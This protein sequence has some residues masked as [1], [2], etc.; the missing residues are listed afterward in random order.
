MRILDVFDLSKQ[1]GDS[2]ALEEISF[3]LESGD[4]LFVGGQNG[5]GK[6]TLL[7]IISGLRKPTTGSCKLT[8]TS[9]FISGV[10]DDSFLYADLTVE[11]N[12][13]FF[14]KIYGIKNH[15]DAVLNFMQIFKLLEKR[16][17][18]VKNL[19]FGFEKRTAIARAVLINPSVLILDEP[20]TGLD[21]SSR[22]EVLKSIS[23]LISS[24]STIIFSSHDTL[25][26]KRLASKMAFLENGRLKFFGDFGEGERLIK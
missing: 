11:E 26:A 15:P 14:A 9:K 20:T 12:L 19:S 1:Y 23:S 21:I 25:V 2:F 13:L 6:T 10:F 22:E 17:C 24:G 4:A 3:S 8:D 18:F 5:A 7:E 16:N